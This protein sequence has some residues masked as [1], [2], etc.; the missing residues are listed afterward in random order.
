MV[1]RSRFELETS[2]TLD[3]R[4]VRHNCQGE[5]QCGCN[6]PSCAAKLDER[7]LVFFIGKIILKQEYLLEIE[8]I[9]SDETSV[10]L[11]ETLQD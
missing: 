10:C 4:E 9:F 5:I 3:A 11:I 7:T 8:V 2:S 1:D 6:F